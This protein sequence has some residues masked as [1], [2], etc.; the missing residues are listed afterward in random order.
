MRREGLKAAVLGVGL[1]LMLSL[2]GMVRLV[3]V[4]VARAKE[5][6]RLVDGLCSGEDGGHC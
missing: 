5:V 3:A 2:A 4:E 1:A 6:R